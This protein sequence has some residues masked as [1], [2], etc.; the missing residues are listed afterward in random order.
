KWTAAKRGFHLSPRPVRDFFSNA[1][2]TPHTPGCCGTETEKHPG[3]GPRIGLR[4]PGKISDPLKWVPWGTKVPK[5]KKSLGEGTL[6]KQVRISRF[7]IT[8]RKTH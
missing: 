6:K 1:C 3:Q 2:N 5:I 8:E 7:Y 4:F